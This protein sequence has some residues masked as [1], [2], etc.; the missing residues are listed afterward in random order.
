MGWIDIKSIDDMDTINE[1]YGGTEKFK[2][3]K[4]KNNN[5]DD[6]HKPQG[7]YSNWREGDSYIGRRK[8][9]RN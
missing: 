4:S 1:L 2:Y 5:E 7:M 9:A 6:F 8:K 3:E